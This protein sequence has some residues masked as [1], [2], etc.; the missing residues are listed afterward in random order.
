M[1][2]DILHVRNCPNAAVLET[3]LAPLFATH[4]QIEVRRH[5]VAAGDDAV[6]LGMTGSPPLLVDGADPVARPGH[7]PS[8]HAASAPTSRGAPDRRHRSGSYAKRSISAP[9]GTDPDS[10]ARGYQGTCRLTHR[11]A[12][13]ITGRPRIDSAAPLSRLRITVAW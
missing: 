12:G 1:R 9:A 5:P 11:S 13:P 2:L 7:E 3:R 4:P 10:A 8:T 6:R